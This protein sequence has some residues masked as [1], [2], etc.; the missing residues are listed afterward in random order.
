MN[1]WVHIDMNK[2]INGKKS[3]L[4]FKV[5][6]QLTNVEGMMELENSPFANHRGN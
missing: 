6:Q 3:A 1:S 2:W 4:F 5:E